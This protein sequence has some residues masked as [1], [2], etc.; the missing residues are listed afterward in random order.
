MSIPR[1]E[2]PTDL[3]PH[4]PARGVTLSLSEGLHADLFG[5]AR[6]DLETA[7][8]LLCVQA[9]PIQAGGRLLGV[10]IRWVDDDAYLRRHSDGLSVASDGYVHA[11]G[12]AE[13]RGL[14][15]VWF[16]THPG[17]GADPHPSVHDDIVDGQLGPVFRLRS[18]S[19][20]YG[21]LVLSPAKEHL[22]FTGFLDDGDH[23][24]PF[25]RVTVVGDRLA[26]IAREDGVRDEEGDGPA[27]TEVF[28]RNVRA[29]GGPVQAALSELA[30]GVV[31][32]GGTGSII[33]EQLVRLGVRHLQLIDPD[34]LDASNVTRVYGS[35]PAD[36]GKYKAQLLAGH[37]QRIAPDLDVVNTVG[38]VN[39]ESVARSL[40]GCDVVFGCTDDNSG[41]LILSR[42]AVFLRIIVIDSGV[43]LSSSPDGRLAGIDARV[44]VLKPGSACLVCRGRIDLAR[45]A[46]EQ[47]SA[48]E[49]QRLAA[50]GYAPALR[51]VQPA[52][53][54]YTT[55][56][57]AHAVAEL[58]ELLTGYGP[59]PR[60]TET[61][62]R[63]H[64]RE[65][66]TNSAVPRAGHFCDP[67]GS[68]LGAGRGEPFL[69]KTWTS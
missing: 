10:E 8:V 27:A 61:L 58:L 11:L 43:L 5:A 68:Y 52:V 62:I 21:S 37:L 7:G 6:N 54:T 20:F 60:P 36:V 51:G 69:G 30:V 38:T 24:L 1:P 23:R 46:A 57:G 9:G 25:D 15:P 40:G 34:T 44:T 31:G 14:V 32:C 55:M 59:E 2:R 42:L 47:M 12:E 33:A 4:S 63:A 13:S 19:S 16:H 22:R 35:T 26:T 65:I 66:S 53:V 29:F 50:E 18:G 64:D 48:T 17:V 3:L 49:H 41:R 39:D 28:S 56:V 45:A 67:E